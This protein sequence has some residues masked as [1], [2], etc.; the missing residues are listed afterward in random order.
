MCIVQRTVFLHPTVEMSRFL[1]VRLVRLIEYFNIKYNDQDSKDD[2]IVDR[3]ALV[4][5]H[6]KL[7]DVLNSG[8]YDVSDIVIKQAIEMSLEDVLFC[9]FTYNGTSFLLCVGA[10]S[11]CYRKCLGLNSCHSGSYM[12]LQHAS[13]PLAVGPTN[14]RDSFLKSAVRLLFSEDGCNV[15]YYNALECAEQKKDWTS[16]YTEWGCTIETLRSEKEEIEKI[17]LKLAT[18]FFNFL[19]MRVS[20]FVGLN[21]QTV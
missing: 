2:S 11:K 4:Y 16:L 21:R 12:T 14:L 5:V 7:L 13:T 8:Q 3:N 18:D 1:P 9:L 20:A 10:C 15:S 19:M 6:S 17:A